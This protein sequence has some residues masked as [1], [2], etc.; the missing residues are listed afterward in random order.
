MLLI[1]FLLAGIILQLMA[2]GTAQ[3]AVTAAAFSAAR[4]ATRSATPYDTALD[5]AKQY[6]NGFLHDWQ[7]RISVSLLAP[8]GLD[9]GDK[10]TVEVTY[11]AAPLFSEF[12]M[13]A[14]KGSSTQVMEELP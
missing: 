5:T 7:S 1:I 13:P 11:T 6:G 8:D 12:P 14:V 10:I 3:L 9:P 2:V 4:A